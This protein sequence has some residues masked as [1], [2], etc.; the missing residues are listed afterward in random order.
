MKTFKN[1]E[2]SA[3]RYCC[4]ES[5]FGARREEGSTRR[6]E[7][8]TKTQRSRSQDLK[9]FKNPE[10]SAPRYC[11]WESYFGARREEGST[12]RI[13]FTTKTQR[14]RSQDL[15]TFKNPEL[16][17]PRYCCWE[18]YFGA[19]RE[20]GSKGGKRKEEGS[21]R[22]IEFTTKTQRSRSQDLKTFK[23]RNFV[24]RDIVAGN[25]T[26][27]RAERRGVHGGLNSPQRHRDHGVRI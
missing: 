7:F 17:A 4:W 1:P 3:P 22:R 20:E 8:T 18:S 2:L 16:S 12:R 14:S 6:I 9:T 5:Y 10:L 23:I 11:C 13:E 26:S 25:H 21:T 19:R 15:K 27:E 24:R